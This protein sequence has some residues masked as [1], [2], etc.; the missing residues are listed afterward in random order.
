MTILGGIALL[1]PGEVLPIVGV[2]VLMVMGSVHFLQGIAV[3]SCLFHRRRI[4]PFFR[5]AVY[6]MIFLQQFLLLGVVAIGLF[7]LW[8]DFR[9]RW[10]SAAVEK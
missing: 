7:D 6:A 3:V 9:K 8:F 2:N 4:P 10:G 1:L 5:G